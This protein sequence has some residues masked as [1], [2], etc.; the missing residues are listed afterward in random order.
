MEVTRENFEEIL[1]LLKESI[2]GADYIAFDIEFSGK[3]SYRPLLN[4]FALNIGIRTRIK[5]EHSEF[6]SP[7]DRYL[8]VK[9]VV[10][11][12]TAIQVGVCTFAW[13]TQSR[14]YRARPFNFYTFPI[15]RDKVRDSMQ[16]F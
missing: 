13:H 9:E 8:K 4:N 16:K 14:E 2:Q 15:S 5:T 11:E 3:L 7:V 1:P 6:D 12:F 10:Q